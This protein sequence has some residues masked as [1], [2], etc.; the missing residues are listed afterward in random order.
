MYVSRQHRHETTKSRAGLIKRFGS[1]RS[2]N[3]AIEFAMVF[4]IYLAMV[5][6]LVTAG[7]YYFT[8]NGLQNAV[9]TASRKIRT[10]Q[11]QTAGTT[12]E[13]FEQEICNAGAFLNCDKLTVILQRGS[14]WDEITPVSCVENG[15]LTQSSG[16][17][18]PVSDFAGGA[19]DVVLVTAC[20]DWSF[21]SDIADVQTTSGAF[22][23]P[24]A[25]GDGVKNLSWHLQNDPNNPAKKLDSNGILIQ[26]SSAFRT[27]PYQ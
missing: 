7:M 21:T 11:A 17:T 9:E 19:G 27:E 6:S 12:V 3:A 20:Y 15:A 13:Q 25:T 26:A 22:D 10:G 1:D 5:L 24:S 16:T 23:D 8:D 4:P 14:D 2:G 18:Q